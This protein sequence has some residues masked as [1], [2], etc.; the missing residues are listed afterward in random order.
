MKHSK[1]IAQT[2]HHLQGKLD[3]IFM[4]FHLQKKY[5][6][7]TAVVLTTTLFPIYLNYVEKTIETKTLL[8]WLLPFTILLFSVIKTLWDYKQKKYHYYSIVNP[9]Q[10]KEL[11]HSLSLPKQM[12][13]SGYSIN[14]FYNGINN[15]YYVVSD[16]INRQLQTEKIYHFHTLKKQFRIGQ[17][18]SDL[19]PSILNE[20]FSNNRSVLFNGTL[21]RLAQELYLDR[22]SVYL[23]KTHYFDSQCTNEIV[24]KKYRSANQMFFIFDGGDLLA[25]KEEHASVLFDLDESPCSN[26]IGVSTLAIT[27][28]NYVIIGKQALASK[29]NAGRYAPSGSGSS[30]FTDIIGCSTLNEVLIKGME[31]E[32]IEELNIPAHMPIHTSLLGYVRLLERGGKPDFF[33]VTYIN[34]TKKELEN[35]EIRLME[36]DLQDNFEFLP[37]E[38]IETLPAVLR[39]FCNQHIPEKK[40]SIQ[41]YLLTLFLEELQK[42]GELTEYYNDLKK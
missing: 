18:I 35:R 9:W 5:L 39:T 15:E 14:N 34:A 36:K 37:F 25:K 21:L 26:Q 42:T 33:G 16:E 8:V 24:Y 22:N 1:T 4:S 10:K 41:V 40:I 20:I 2:I 23:Q 6:L 38:D 27:S 28:D 32:L 31:R 7:W 12:E 30:E 29:A 19:V 13:E 3:G 17:E 11:L